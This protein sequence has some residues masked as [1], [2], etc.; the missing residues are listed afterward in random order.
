MR[1][2]AAA[3]LVL[4]VLALCAA[5]CGRQEDPKRAAPA[6]AP[7]AP[8]GTIV[9]LGDSLTAGYGVA[10]RE[11]WPALLE[12]RLRAAGKRWRVVNAGVSGETSS[13]T[14]SRADWVV[15]QLRPDVVILAIGAND[16]L[17]GIDPKLVRANVIAIV[18]KLQAGGATVVL[19]GMRMVVN[20]G[21]DYTKAFAAVYPAAARETGVD[22]VPFLL[23]GVA[24]VPALNQEDGIHP[25]AAG[26]RIIAETVYPHALRSVEERERRHP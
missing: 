16:G 14:L 18:R 9:A 23:E 25:T 22:L 24:A 6:A 4:A 3:P 12:A 13:G 26:H 7:E 19:A 5:G 8:A 17:R 21:A 20:M 10:E 15:R 1:W 11:A 2:L